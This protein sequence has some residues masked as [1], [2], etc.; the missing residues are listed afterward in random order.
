MYVV[1]NYLYLLEISHTHTHKK[2]VPPLLPCTPSWM[3]V[4]QSLNRAC[5]ARSLWYEVLRCSSSCD[6]RACS[7]DSCCTDSVPMSTPPPCDAAAWDI[8]HGGKARAFEIL[9]GTREK[10]VRAGLFYAAVLVEG[11]GISG[12]C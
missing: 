8:T 10:S 7:A 9:K 2:Y 1:L 11:S 12:L 6:S 5:A 3:L 4:M